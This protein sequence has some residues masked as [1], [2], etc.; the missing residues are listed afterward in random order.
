MG[1]PI[2]EYV[3]QVFDAKLIS[4]PTQSSGEP[5]HFVL[6]I[7]ADDTFENVLLTKDV[8]VVTLLKYV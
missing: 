4:N 8:G 6:H 2:D 1:N 5:S 7:F 3:T